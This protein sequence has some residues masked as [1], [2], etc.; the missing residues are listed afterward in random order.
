MI[1]AVHDRAAAAAVERAIAERADARAVTVQVGRR[2]LRRRRGARARARARPA[3]RRCR[4]GGACTRT[5][6]GTL[7]SNVETF[8]QVAVLL[9]LGARRFA[10][11]GTHDEPGTTLLT[12]SGAVA[13]PGVVEIP[14]GTPLSIVLTAAGAAPDLAAV[15]TGGYHGTWVTPDPALLVSRAGLTAAGASFGAGVLIALDHSTC[16]LGELGRVA[17]WLAAESARQCGPCRFGLPALADDVRSIYRGDARGAR[18]RRPARPGG[19]RTRRLRPPRRHGPV[20]HLGAA[21]A[22]RRDPRPSERRLRPSG[23]R[24]CCRSEERSS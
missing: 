22:A 21:A 6:T 16:S 1:V 7:L 23:S 20:H 13:R 11:T 18:R 14:I 19:G 10:A 15:I 4:P 3:A 2:R 9:R 24:V 17:A 5:E 12:I 8:A